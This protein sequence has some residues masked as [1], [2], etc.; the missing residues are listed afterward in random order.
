M[1]GFKHKRV[2][3]TCSVVIVIL[4]MFIA[5]NAVIKNIPNMSGNG[6]SFCLTLP[7]GLIFQASPPKNKLVRFMNKKYGTKFEQYNGDEFSEYGFRYSHISAKDFDRQYNGIIVSTS[8]YPNHYFFV[9]DYYGEIHDDYGCH[10]A[11]SEANRIIEDKLLDIMD[12]DLKAALHPNCFQDNVFSEA[13]TG[14]EYL[15]NG[16]YIIKIFICGDGGNAENEFEKIAECVRPYW[17][18][19]TFMFIYYLDYDVFESVDTNDYSSYSGDIEYNK[20]GQGWGYDVS[21]EIYKWEWIL[22]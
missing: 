12:F 8:E 18:N 14:L 3:I 4:F 10:L 15:E 1:N 5:A 6:R 22:K 7:D 19:K 11:E 17:D 21:G 2:F 9:C 16:D 20:M 13:P